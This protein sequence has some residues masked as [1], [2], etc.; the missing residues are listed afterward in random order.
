MWPVG[1]LALLLLNGMSLP[2]T[3]HATTWSGP[4]GV[5]SQALVCRVAVGEPHQRGVEQHFRGKPI[6]RTGDFIFCV[7]LP[8]LTLLGIMVIGRRIISC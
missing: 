8:F 5:P 6:D 3:L 1:G 2:P 7:I 4:V